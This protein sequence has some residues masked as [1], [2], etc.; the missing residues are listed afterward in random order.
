MLGALLLTAAVTQVHAQDCAATGS[1]AMVAE[2]LAASEAAFTELDVETFGLAADQ[3]ALLLP[4]VEDAVTP[5][6]AAWSHRVFGLRLVLE[7]RQE[8]ATLPFA[9]ARALEPEYS[10]PETLIPAGHQVR[11]IYA[12]FDLDTGTFETLPEP[13]VGHLTFD[14]SQGIV[15]PMAWPTL[16]QVFDAAGTPTATRY[17]FPGDAMPAYEAVPPPIE[18]LTLVERLRLH[19]GK[20]FTVA[21]IAAVA[22]GA[23]Y[24]LA[25]LW[26]RDFKVYNPSYDK[27]DLDGLYQRNHMAVYSASGLAVVALAGGVGGVLLRTW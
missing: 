2:R 5:D 16:V 26:S 10:F 18:V 27:D 22:S 23:S 15:R 21:G 20:F 4:C 3:A 9:A 12:S 17:L 25:A 11:S 19:R 8:E 6:L 14:G 7:G 13:L 24:T 1:V